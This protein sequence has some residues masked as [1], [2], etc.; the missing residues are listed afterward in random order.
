MRYFFFLG[1]AFSGKSF[2]SSSISR[3]FFL[4]SPLERLVLGLHVQVRQPLD[5]ALEKF[6]AHDQEEVEQPLHFGPALVLLFGHFAAFLF[7]F[8]DDAAD[9]V[10]NVLFVRVEAHAGALENLTEVVVLL[11][12]FLFG[13]QVVEPFA[14]L[15]AHVE[16]PAGRVPLF[17]VQ[18][19]Q[20]RLL[21]T[22]K[23]GLGLRLAFGRAGEAGAPGS[24]VRVLFVALVVLFGLRDFGDGVRFFLGVPLW[25]Y[26]GSAGT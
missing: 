23:H 7:L 6:A 20:P 13:V 15:V 18:G 19:L 9:F 17:E 16:I 1:F 10:L 4:V 12:F 2:S 26:S 21:D 14:L 3:H 5:F 11:L 22:Q 24:L 25:S 8:T